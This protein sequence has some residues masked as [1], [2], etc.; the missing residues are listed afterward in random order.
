MKQF[1][2]GILFYSSIQSLHQDILGKEKYMKAIDLLWI[3]W[4]I[5]VPFAIL[6]LIATMVLIRSSMRDKQ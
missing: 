1:W 4:R 2:A 3:D 6:G 5:T